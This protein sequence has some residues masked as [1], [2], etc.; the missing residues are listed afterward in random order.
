MT[1]EVK[2]KLETY[3]REQLVKTGRFSES[4]IV[5]IIETLKSLKCLSSEDA[6]NAF[7]KASQL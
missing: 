2:S 1:T 6:V 4:E 5:S 7:I 3:A